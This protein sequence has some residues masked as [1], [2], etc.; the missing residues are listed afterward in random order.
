M[1]YQGPIRKQLEVHGFLV[2]VAEVPLIATL[3]TDR[4]SLF[5]ERF[6]V[7]LNTF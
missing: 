6:S 1:L 2:R 4:P 5:L 7:F 3:G